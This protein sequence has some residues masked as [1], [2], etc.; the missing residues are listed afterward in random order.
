MIL[1]V[2]NWV[3]FKKKTNK[4]IHHPLLYAIRAIFNRIYYFG[5]AYCN[6]W[7]KEKPCAPVS[8][9]QISKQTQSRL[10]SPR[11]PAL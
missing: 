4:Q 2:V 9:N 10:D 1:W 7:S 3:Q 11:F 5:F 8:T 6:D